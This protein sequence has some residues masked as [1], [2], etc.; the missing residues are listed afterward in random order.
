MP[1]NLLNE[2]DLNNYLEELV[3]GEDGQEH[4]FANA[5]GHSKKNLQDVKY[6][7]ENKDSIVRFILQQYMKHRIRSYLM[8]EEKE[9]L[10]PVSQ[11]Q[12]GLPDWALRS[13]SAGGLVFKFDKTKVPEELHNN[14]ITIRDFLYSS[15]ESYINKS[16]VLAQETNKKI[17]IHPE[18]LKTNNA[19]SSFEKVLELSEKWHHLMEEKGKIKEKHKQLYQSSL[20]GTK[21][22]QDLPNEMK[23][24]RLLT[25]EA[26]DFESNYMGHCVGQGNYDKG[27]INGTIEIYSIRDKN[28]EP[29]ATLEIRGNDVY[30]CKGKGNK[31]PVQ[32]YMPSIQEFVKIKKWNIKHDIKNIGLIQKDNEYYSIFNLPDGFIVDGDLDLSDFDLKGCNLNIQVHGFLN[33]SKT[34]NL[35]KELDFSHTQKVDLSYTDLSGVKTLKA[36]KGSI[37]L[38]EAK[39]LPKELDF[40]HTQDV[41]LGKVDLSGVGLKL[42]QGSISLSGAKNLPKELDFSHTQDVYLICTNLSDIVLKLPQGSINLSGAK[43]LPKELDFSHTRK[44]DLYETDLSGVKTLKAPRGSINLTDAKNLPKE[45]DFSHTQ[46]VYLRKTDLSGVEILKA[47]QGSINL[48]D[49][50]NLPKELDFF[51]TQ[52]V[53]LEKVNLSG[54]KTLKASKGSINLTEAKNLPKELDFSHTQKVDLS[55]TDL[56]GVVLEVSQGSLNLS[57]AKNLPKE[58]DFSHTQKVDLRDTDLSGVEILK[59][60]QRSISLS[61]VI[62]LPK[63]LDFSHTQ[64]VYL[65]CTNLSGV[66]LN[67]P[68]GSISLSGVINLPKELDFSHTQDVNLS[69][70]NLSSVETLKAPKGSIDLTDAKNPPKELDFSHTQKVD[71]RRTDLSNVKILKLPEKDKVLS[72]E[73]TKFPKDYEFF[74]KKPEK[75]KFFKGFLSIFKVNQKKVNNNIKIDKMKNGR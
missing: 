7:E 58:L 47:P 51:H 4:F 9:Y 23:V 37:K 10:I 69:C 32:K 72:V 44:V 3:W 43:N 19:Y 67:L 49:A 35:P 73:N 31:I 22:I 13:L 27:V 68:Q 18:Y 55:K 70:T 48:T 62:G 63:E 16:V 25:S 61:G 8:A 21:F 45:L 60:P 64:D 40:S 59:A 26:L 5:A 41:K 29:H 34:K 52:D 42:P 75:S 54:V 56:S 1:I 39:N 36:P 30:Q 65:S 11:Q 46:D 20:K 53:K 28:G 12:E 66:G 6:I 57:G 74:E 33:L 71:L 38:T 50:K 24:Y 17:K 15:A 14:L 2:K